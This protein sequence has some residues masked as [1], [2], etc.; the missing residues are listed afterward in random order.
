MIRPGRPPR[1]GINLKVRISIST[2]KVIAGNLGT[3]TSVEYTG[4][5]G[6]VNLGQRY[7]KQRP[8]RRHP[9]FRQH[10]ADDQ[11]PVR[12]GNRQ[13]VTVKAYNEPVEC[14]EVTG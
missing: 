4:I 11:G 9:R 2:G 6:A 10:P 8:A 3:M 7:E 12:F 1:I 13:L 5:G 14:H